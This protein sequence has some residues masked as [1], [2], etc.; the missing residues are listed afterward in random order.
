MVD[1]RVKN[2]NRAT[3]TKCKASSWLAHWEKITGQ[4]ASLCFVKDC[5]D[6]PSAGG[7]VQKDGSSDQNWYVVPLCD[8]CS[9]K[10]GQDLDIWD[11]ATL[12]PAVETSLSPLVP[13]VRQILALRA[14]GSFR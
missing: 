5:I 4:N 13:R 8:H 11:L 12:V 2:L 6:Q 14:A 7:L 1:M 3:Q 9:K 10:T